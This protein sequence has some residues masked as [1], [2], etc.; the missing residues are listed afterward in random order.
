MKRQGRTG[1]PTATIGG[2]KLPEDMIK[3]LEGYSVLNK[4]LQMFIDHVSINSII[5]RYTF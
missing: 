4:F 5:N 3:R 1:I 2:G